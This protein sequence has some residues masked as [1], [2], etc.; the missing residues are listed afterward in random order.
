MT[1]EQSLAVLAIVAFAAFIVWGRTARG[2]L[3]LTR[4]YGGTV[5][6]AARPRQSAARGSA[7]KRGRRMSSPQGRA[8]RSSA[9]RGRGR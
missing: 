3:V 1:L 6:A 5:P 4:W 7:P 2:R 8:S 9:G